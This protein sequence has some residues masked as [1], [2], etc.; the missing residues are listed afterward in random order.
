LLFGSELALAE[1]DWGHP[2]NI[3]FFVNVPMYLLGSQHRRSIFCYVICNIEK[4]TEKMVSPIGRK[5]IQFN[6]HNTYKYLVHS[7]IDSFRTRAMSLG[8]R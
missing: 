2:L 5:I 4:M 8:S 3:V 1:Q 7:K 6:H